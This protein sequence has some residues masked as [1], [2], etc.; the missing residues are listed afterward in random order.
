MPLHR[1]SLLTTDC[2]EDHQASLLEK[3]TYFLALFS[4]LKQKLQ[5]CKYLN[6]GR[7]HSWN[8]VLFAHT[9]RHTNKFRVR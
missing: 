2:N 1:S 4:K 5:F 8:S 9:L 7:K 3:G 6:G